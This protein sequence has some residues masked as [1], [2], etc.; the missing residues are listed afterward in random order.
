MNFTPA[1][2]AWELHSFHLC[3]L[4]LEALFHSPLFSVLKYLPS[5][6][7]LSASREKRH[8]HLQY[9]TKQ[10]TATSSQGVF[11]HLLGYI[12]F[13]VLREVVDIKVSLF[14]G[15]DIIPFDHQVGEINTTDN[16]VGAIAMDKIIN[17]GF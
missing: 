6:F 10:V 12:K 1:L 9:K 4:L 2:L 5:G 15:M 7:I 14:R 8:Q 16:A 17:G 13:D 3:A 11:K